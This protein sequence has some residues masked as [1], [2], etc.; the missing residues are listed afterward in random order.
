METEETK[1]AEVVEETVVE[2]TVAGPTPEVTP[3]PVVET[4]IEEEPAHESVE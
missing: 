4:A 2:E 1:N 3:E